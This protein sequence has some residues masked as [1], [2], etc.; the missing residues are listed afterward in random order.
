MNFSKGKSIW[1]I[2]A[3]LTLMLA[4]S[5]AIAEKAE[6]KEIV[7]KTE[8]KETVEKAEK[9]ESTE[10]AEKKEQP[11][12]G[13]IAVVNG[14][15]I[16]KD[17]FDSK[18]TQYKQ[19]IK[20]QKIPEAQ[21]GEIKKKILERLVND[22]LL[23]QESQTKGIKVDGEKVSLR[24]AT[25]KQKFPNPTEFEKALKEMNVS[26]TEVKSRIERGIAIQELIDSHVT[27]KI[28]VSEEEIKEFYDSHKQFFKESEQVKASHILIMTSDRKKPVK[29]DD[30]KKNEEKKKAEA[31]KKIE[32]IQKKVKKGDDFAALA[33][34]FSECPSSNNGGD[35]G[36]F[37]RG[38]MVKPFEEVAFS[39]KLNEISDIVETRFGYHLIKATEKKAEKAT[40]YEDAKEN[41]LKHLKNEKTQAKVKEY[42][43]TIR[44]SAKIETFL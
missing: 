3:V 23:Y 26:E 16:S 38:Q 32:M 43:E 20:G 21:I 29:K 28:A 33:K 6:K 15:V 5:P 44:K 37:K 4:V 39:L 11:S 34:E 7:E 8:K 19:R 35:L 18:L 41:I 30:E 27:D 2:L 1:P 25:V 42:I 13:K 9:K 22:E 31:K 12:T 17:E 10:K 36:F 14:S 40:V 24:L